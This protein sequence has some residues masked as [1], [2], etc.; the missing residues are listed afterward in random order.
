M[1]TARLTDAFRPEAARRCSPGR[2]WN[3]S[4]GWCLVAWL[5][6]IVASL[7]G[8]RGEGFRNPPPS[9]FG[10]GRA[11]G[12]FAHVDD[13]SAVQHNPA[14][15]VDLQH[16]EAQVTPSLIYINVEHDS[17][18]G[19]AETVEPL[20]LLPNFFASAPLLDGK[21]VSGI[22]VTVPYGIA[23]E[24][25]QSGAFANP[26]GLR[27]Q[28]PYFAE[29]MTINVN[30]TVAFRI[31]DQLSLGVGLDVM[32]SQLK[33]KQLYPWFLFPGS[34]GTEPDGR[35]RA[36][37]DGFAFGGNF[38]LTWQIAE[39]HRLAFTYRS[40]MTTDFEGS[41]TIN[42]ITPAAA[43]FGATSRS[44][45]STRIKFPTII[46]LGYGVQVT[47]TLR[48]EVAG[49]WLEFSNFQ[50]LDLNVGNNGFL[51]PSTSIPQNWKDTF[52]VGF[53]GDWQ[54]ASEWVLRFGFQ[55]YQ[56][57]VPDAT[58]STTIPDSDQ[59]VI[60]VGLGY[61]R[62]RHSFEAAYGLDFYERRTISNN[63]NPVF[64]GVF[65]FN[66]HLFSLAYR[67]AL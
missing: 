53:G 51:F 4:R 25:E 47:D 15:L 31:V 52:T 21:I 27:Y 42:N 62:G 54:F 41:F 24:W 61:R 57:P 49:E 2:W 23:N 60:T 65:D 39:K 20:K 22:G 5:V 10:L 6:L 67:Y 13:S 17:A 11:G 14:N 26:A 43:G 30:P 40:P 58:L 28:A 18:A 46:G 35:L 63:Q 59:N 19:H 66:V 45:F 29:L 38:G 12:R 8:A 44:D 48:L 64:N 37:G 1:M 16:P 34:G 33:F 56:T 3:R 7:C 55:H 32:W 50:S 36:R 9:T